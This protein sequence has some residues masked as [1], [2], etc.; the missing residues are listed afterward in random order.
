MA[1]EPGDHLLTMLEHDW[2][3]DTSMTH[4]SFLL[5]H[6][7]FVDHPSIETIMG[8][9]RA[10]ETVAE[11][12]LR[13][14]PDLM[15]LCTGSAFEGVFPAPISDQEFGEGNSSGDSETG[16][17]RGGGI[18]PEADLQC[19]YVFRKW[20]I[21]D[22]PSEQKEADP[23]DQKDPNTQ[24]GVGEGGLELKRSRKEAP[25]S[26]AHL[27]TT[28]RPGKV[29]LRIRTVSKEL[30]KFA[31]HRAG[32]TVDMCLSPQ[33]LGDKVCHVL[34]ELRGMDIVA[35]SVD[36][37][38][39][40][41]KKDEAPGKAAAAWPEGKAG[42]SDGAATEQEAKGEVVVF[43]F[44]SH[45]WPAVA[46]EWRTRRRRHEWPESADINAAISQGCHL[47]ATV[48]STGWPAAKD[49]LE[50]EDL[51]W[52]LSFMAAER[53]LV[54]SLLVAQRKAYSLLLTLYHRH[55]GVKGKLSP[56][57]VQHVVFWTCEQSTSAIWRED[58]LAECLLLL[59]DRLLHFV[60]DGVLPNYF[61]PAQNMF[62]DLSQV[63]ALKLSSLVAGVRRNPIACLN[64][65]YN[66]RQ[67]AEGT[68]Y[69][70]LFKPV[71]TYLE[72]YPDE[73]H[74]LECIVQAAFTV[75]HVFLAR[76]H[77]DRALVLF[78]EG[79]E[80]MLQI[81]RPDARSLGVLQLTAW[82]FLHTGLVDK[83]IEYYEIICS[84]SK[85]EQVADQGFDFQTCLANLACLYH[86]KSCH[87]P[88]ETIQSHLVDKT[89]SCFEIAVSEGLTLQ[90]ALHYAIFLLKQG[91][92]DKAVS[93]LIDASS[94]DSDKSD[95]R[96]LWAHVTSFVEVEAET[97]DEDLSGEV[98]EAGLLEVPTVVLV[99]YLITKG[100]VAL[101]LRKQF[102]ESNKALARLC[103]S[104][105]NDKPAVS[106]SLLGYCFMASDDH[107]SALKAFGTAMKRDNYYTLAED[108]YNMC[109][110][111]LGSD[112][113]DSDEDD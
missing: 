15:A 10:N 87:I 100:L 49:E 69:Q 59:L 44:S 34:G 2:V 26:L 37:L 91:K 106:W 23:K 4:L 70:D 68:S 111:K 31:V 79:C 109:K 42:G 22:E 32:E 67:L 6:V 18:P 101:G 54:C 86:V 108:Q 43:G 25:L 53:A 8:A 61:L 105:L 96:T 9:I 94:Q 71:L 103:R 13:G 89:R 88:D 47:V 12:E 58:N 3:S 74:P 65:C 29:R 92:P 57:Q 93:I 38:S 75:G 27:V 78:E 76:D 77:K 95:D 85:A 90:V 99:Q 21:D 11:S 60:C 66:Q 98:R 112:V 113:S 104:S 62:S 36:A 97:L 102:K 20:T 73:E 64:A 72:S 63:D 41:D 28:D 33:Q 45:C 17:L 30:S 82:L 35:A 50:E 40:N 52:D 110:A 48:P 19:L 81:C 46:A 56:Q 7:L 107:H 84:L 83:A 16:G 5:R 55:I 80:L 1:S 39:V 24:A 51:T 14:N